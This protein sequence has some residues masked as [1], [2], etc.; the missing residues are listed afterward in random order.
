MASSVRAVRFSRA[1][2]DSCSCSNCCDISL[3]L[4]SNNLSLSVESLN[5]PTGTQK[6][7][8]GGSRSM[9][10][11]ANCVEPSVARVH[12]Q[13]KRSPCYLHPFERCGASGLDESC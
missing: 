1:V 12:G 3:N 6:I 2:E 8:Q 9:S 10:L 11:R 5:I 4:C 7:W 13:A